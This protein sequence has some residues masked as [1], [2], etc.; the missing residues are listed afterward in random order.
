MKFQILIVKVLM[1]ITV[2]FIFVSPGAAQL[3]SALGN[4]QNV[5]DGILLC[6]KDA[7]GGILNLTPLIVI[8]LVF[9]MMLLICKKKV[10]QGSKF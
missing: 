3:I 9:F 8:G 1:C 2:F 6:D 4:K 10:S 7:G 5:Y